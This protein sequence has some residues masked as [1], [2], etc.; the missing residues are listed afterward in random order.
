MLI[1]TD[2]NGFI[3]PVSSEITSERVY[4]ERRALIKL[5]AGGAAGGGHGGG[6]GGGWGGGA[7]CSCA[8]A[9]GVGWGG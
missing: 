7:A 1:K 8:G 6:G 3:H 9:W 2:H 4:R 5:M